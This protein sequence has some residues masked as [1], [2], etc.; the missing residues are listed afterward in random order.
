LLAFSVPADVPRNG[1]T[2]RC[3]AERFSE[4]RDRSVLACL[5]AQM[6]RCEA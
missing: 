2:E 3:D 6:M 5:F 4:N 1:L